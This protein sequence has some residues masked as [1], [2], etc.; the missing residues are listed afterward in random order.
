MQIASFTCHIGVYSQFLEKT[1]T[2]KDFQYIVL[3]LYFLSKVGLL[4]FLTLF[5]VTLVDAKPLSHPYFIFLFFLSVALRNEKSRHLLNKD[6]RSKAKLNF[7]TKKTDKLY[8]Q[9]NEA[10]R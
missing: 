3:S 7:V 5:L 6:P 10:R 8:K 4:G 1:R 2:L 9:Y